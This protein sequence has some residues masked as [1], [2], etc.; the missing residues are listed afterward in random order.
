MAYP[1]KQPF[2]N[3]IYTVA[4]ADITVATAS[5]YCPMVGQGDVRRVMTVITGAITTADETLTLYKNGTTTG[6]AITVTQSG[7]AA[8]D[9][10]YVDIPAGSV[11][12][13]FGDYLTVVSSNASG[14]TITAT[15]VYVVSGL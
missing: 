5:A 14:G 7:S 6:Y 4:H 9:V 12:V 15:V 8:G 10:D 3:Q 11:T 2:T 13:G 1:E